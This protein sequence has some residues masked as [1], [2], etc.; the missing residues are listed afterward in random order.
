MEFIGYCKK[1]FIFE[2]SLSHFVCFKKRR[3]SVITDSLFLST[4]IRHLVGRLFFMYP[5]RKRFRRWRFYLPTLSCFGHVFIHPPSLC[6]TFKWHFYKSKFI[7]SSNSSNSFSKAFISSLASLLYSSSYKSGKAFLN[8][9]LVI[10]FFF[11][12]LFLPPDFI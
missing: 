3:E 4:S 8:S 10:S 12:R 7:K 1:I 6:F 11:E 5:I 2:M 9:V